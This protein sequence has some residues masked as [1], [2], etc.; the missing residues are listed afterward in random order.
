MD[1]LTHTVTSG[2]PGDG[3]GELFDSGLIDTYL[4]FSY[5]FE[6]SGTYDYYCTTHPWM[7]GKVVVGEVSVSYTHLTLPTILLV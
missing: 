7:Q 6:E 2:T 5:T 3:S 1:I 4:Y